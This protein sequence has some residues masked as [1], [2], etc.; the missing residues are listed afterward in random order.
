MIKRS[1]ICIIAL[2]FCFS[3]TGKAQKA[4][5]ADNVKFRFAYMTDVHL[6]YNNAD[7]CFAGFQQALDTA[8]KRNVDFIVFGGDC[9]DMNE[10]G[11][12]LGRADSMYASFKS[13]L[14]KTP[15]KTWPAIGNHDRFF[16]DS[17]GYKDGDE[18]FRK[19]FTDSYYTFEHKGVRFF[20]LNSVQSGEPGTKGYHVG[21]EQM[22]WLQ[23]CLQTV[24]PE[25]PIV[26]V[27]H[28]PVY[29]VSDEGFTNSKELLKAF[30][31]HNLKLVLQGHIHLHEEIYSR[32]VW[33]VSGGAVCS[34]WWEGVYQG[35]EE[36]FLVVDVDSE[37]NFG[38]KYVDYG[39]VVKNPRYK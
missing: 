14:D 18:L 19:Y 35:T 31:G 6:K 39:W 30:E 37:N 9:L 8:K 33:Y 15:I 13:F 27:T 24:S 2:A 36:G 23:G 21:T 25:T 34:G 11:T 10:Y 5:K 7:N 26:A 12:S 17:E 3:L 29:S 4:R 16:K 32:K 1:L 22:K 28:I 20:V 38:W